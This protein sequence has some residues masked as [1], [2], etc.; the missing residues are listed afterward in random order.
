[1]GATNKTHPWDYERAIGPGTAMLLKVHPSNYRIM[2]FTCQVA[3]DEL[4][5]LAA[6]HQ[7]IVVEDL[8]SG[9]LVD[10]GRYGVGPEPTVQASLAAGVDIV[11]FSGDKLLGGPQAGLILGRAGLLRIL[12]ENQLLRALR[13]DKF[14]LAALEATLQAYVREE[15]EQSLPVLRMLTV[16]PARLQQR[17]ADLQKLLAGRLGA[18][19]EIAVRQGYSMVGGGALPLEELPTTLVSCDRAHVLRILQARPKAWMRRRAPASA[20]PAWRSACDAATPRCWRT[21]RMT[22]Y[23]STPAPSVR[24]RLNHW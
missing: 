4:V 21:S 20:Q 16:A 9:A 2:G 23:C 15:A 12:K 17:A 7:V 19:C 3:D 13:V 6:R 5:G 1:M 18:D 14:T 22:A 10:L 24:M 11:T 8:G